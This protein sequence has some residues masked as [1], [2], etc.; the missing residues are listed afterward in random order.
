M[1]NE[2]IYNKDVVLFVCD[3]STYNNF[4]S[5][6]LEGVSKFLWVVNPSRKTLIDIKKNKI[7]F[8]ANSLSFFE[9]I[10]LTKEEYNYYLKNIRFK[11]INRLLFF[12]AKSVIFSE[13][14][15]LPMT[16]LSINEDVFFYRERFNEFL[17]I[18][19]NKKTKLFFYDF[20]DYLLF[21]EKIEN[22]RNLFS[23]IKYEAAFTNFNE[24]KY[25]LNVYVK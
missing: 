11:A 8:F 24:T 17:Y 23:A 16:N 19:N 18:K 14:C 20:E 12:N 7:N 10:P 9:S 2:K 13:T 1:I 6:N 21:G 4:I 25:K 15:Y 5:C 3:D 22:A